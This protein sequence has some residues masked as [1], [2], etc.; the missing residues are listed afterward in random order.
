MISKNIGGFA[1]SFLEFLS[2]SVEI[3]EENTHRIGMSHKW[4]KLNLPYNASVGRP[5][6]QPNKTHTNK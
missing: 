1:V 2:P 5:V 6:N 3:G 4:S